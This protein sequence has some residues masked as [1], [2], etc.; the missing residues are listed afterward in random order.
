MNRYMIFVANRAVEVMN[1]LRSPSSEIGL[2]SS[3]LFTIRTDKG[4]R[5]MVAIIVGAAGA[6]AQ[7]ILAEV[8]DVG[9]HGKSELAYAASLLRHK[10]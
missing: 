8:S 2:I 5:E 10:L 4:S 1:A 7:Y 6:E 3:D 9:Y